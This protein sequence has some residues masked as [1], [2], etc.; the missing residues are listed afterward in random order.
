M[1]LK[2]LVTGKEDATIRK[3]DLVTRKKETDPRHYGPRFP[4]SL[5]VRDSASAMDV[6]WALTEACMIAI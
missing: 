5:A 2:L 4:D 1:L 3:F 6:R